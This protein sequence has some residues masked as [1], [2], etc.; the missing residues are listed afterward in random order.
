MSVET[1]VSYECL[2][3]VTASVPR[4]ISRSILSVS[5]PFF[6]LVVA[7]AYWTWTNYEKKAVLIRR[8][9]MSVVVVVYISYSSLV[10]ELLSAISCVKINTGEKSD[11]YWASDTS[12]KC[13]HGSHAVL[14]GVLILP[15]IL[16]VLLTFPVGSA[17]YLFLKRCDGKL[18]DPEVK[19]KFGFMYGAYTDKCVFWDCVVLLRKVVLAAVVVFGAS[20]VSNIQ[21]IFAVSILFVSVYLQTRFLPYH[22]DFKDFNSLETH[23]LL[24][25]AFTFLSAL[26]I[27]DPSVGDDGGL[28]VSIFVVSLIVTFILRVIITL[29]LKV[30]K[31]CE[32]SL[33]LKGQIIE[34]TRGPIIVMQ[35]I[36]YSWTNATQRLK[37]VTTSI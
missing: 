25:S 9:I 32:L 12:L 21:N 13:L 7:T 2:F 10:E 19:E 31:Y 6:S 35:L 34:T 20:L 8:L 23:S 26:F 27:N 30:V 18:D 14:V 4:S 33:R 15:L 11:F 5:L 24:V 1:T 16:S 3:S 17:V 22:E 36:R 28:L 29:Y 37:S